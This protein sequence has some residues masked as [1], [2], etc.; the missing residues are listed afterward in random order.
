MNM[1]TF[2]DSLTLAEMNEIW[3]IIHERRIAVANEYRTPLNDEEMSLIENGQWIEAIKLYR[4]R[5]DVD[6]LT[7][8]LKVDA[9]RDVMMSR[10]PRKP[11]Y[12]SPSTEGY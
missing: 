5:N 7:A 4:H 1:R 9:Y 11:F 12:I 10:K 2:V 6:L 3:I 8:K